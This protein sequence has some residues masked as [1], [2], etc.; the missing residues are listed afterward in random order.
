MS[1][2]AKIIAFNAVQTR[3]SM[4]RIFFMLRAPL[5]APAALLT[6]VATNQYQ[7]M[8]GVYSTRCMADAEPSIG[9]GPKDRGESP[10]C[11]GG[12]CVAQPSPHKPADCNIL[13]AVRG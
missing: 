9:G 13:V 7:V 6:A 5:L 1:L 3:P 12:R 11:W 8:Q 10:Y 4:S 2:A